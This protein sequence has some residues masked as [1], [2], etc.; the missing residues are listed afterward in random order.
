MTMQITEVTIHPT[1]EDDV[2]AHVSIVFDNCFAVG[3]IRV[4]QGPTGLFVSFPAKKQRAG[5]D[6]QL[7]YPANAETR[8][9]IQ[10]VILAEYEKI[11][12]SNG[13]VPSALTASERL[14]SLEQLKNDGLINEEEYSCS[15][16][17]EVLEKSSEFNEELLADQ[18]TNRLAKSWLNDNGELIVFLIGGILSGVSLIFTPY[19]S[20]AEY[21]VGRYIIDLLT[22]L[23]AIWIICGLVWLKLY[24]S[25]E[26][27]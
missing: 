8:M 15:P 23:A 14:R 7:A 26:S 9:M 12:G 20:K 2:R 18:R 13:S 1:I 17:A 3:E 25:K 16:E 24:W 27:R 19:P 6:R 10:R 21:T 4:I 22:K 11:V 5:S